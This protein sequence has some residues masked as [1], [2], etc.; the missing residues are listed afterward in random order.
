MKARKRKAQTTECERMAEIS[1]EKV[2]KAFDAISDE[3]SFHDFL[4]NAIALLI[5]VFDIAE[6]PSP[7][8]KKRIECVVGLNW[9]KPKYKLILEEL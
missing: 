8:K 7:E 4:G 5:H 6:R 3:G 2:L 9:I 1:K